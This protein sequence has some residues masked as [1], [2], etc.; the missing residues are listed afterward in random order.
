MT[1]TALPSHLPSTMRAAVLCA[2]EEL[3][4]QER[5]VPRP[6]PGQVL[7]RIEAVGICGSDV[8][9][10]RHGRIGDFVVSA[11]L[12]LGHEP[13][14]TVVALGPGTLRHQVGQ[15]VSLEPGVPC[16]R[17]AQ[18]RQGRYNLCPDV[19][20][21]A[22]PPVDGALCEYVAVDEDF[23]HPAPAPLTAE[24]AALLEPLSVG[25]WA[26]RKGRVGP[27]SRVLVTGAGPIGL[28]AAQTARA[29]GA[30]E[31]VVTDVAP[32]RLDLARQL[33]STATVDVR[34]TRLADTGFEPDVLLEC[35]GVP[36]AVDEAI[37]TVGRAGRAV[38][39]GMGGDSISL[40]LAHVQNFE[41]ELTGTFRYANT[42]PTAIA[43][44]ASG[45]VE[46]GRL[47]THRYGLEEA[48]RALTAGAR[49]HATIKPLV[50][51]QPR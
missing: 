19:S 36:S 9:Y 44:A 5:P 4:I 45:E 42:W 32:H 13:G 7:V 39:V 29:F 35:S 10:Y 27:G 6:G 2:P 49:D 34:S 51:P 43:L 48:E 14:G 12:V 47:V 8:H 37:R 21:Y 40:P 20:F 28:V 22:T 38:L 41:I 17:C 1:A 33:G 23:A 31:V 18:C 16:A 15:L 26:C 3:Q 24:T 11:P 46:L 50:C 25:V 30:T